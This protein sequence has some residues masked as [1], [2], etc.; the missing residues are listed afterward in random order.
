MPNVGTGGTGVAV[1]EVS[2]GGTIAEDGG[3]ENKGEEAEE[4]Q[5]F[6]EEDMH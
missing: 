6:F 3:R 1:C 5:A 4:S 2:L